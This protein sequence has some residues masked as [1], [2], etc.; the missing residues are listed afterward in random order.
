M[1]GPNQNVKSELLGLAPDNYPTAQ[2]AT[3]VALFAGTRKLAIHWIMGPV[4]QKT[5]KSDGA[6]KAK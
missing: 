4:D 5:K 2:Q 3:P 6:G 1:K